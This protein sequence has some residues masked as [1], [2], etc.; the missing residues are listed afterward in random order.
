ML[1]WILMAGS[2]CFA[3]T[4][5]QEKPNTENIRKLLVLTGSGEIGAQ[6]MER[7]IDNFKVTIPDVPASFWDEFKTEVNPNTLIDLIVP[8]Y[9]NHLSNEE[10]DALI[11]FYETPAGKKFTAAL[12]E[13]SQESMLA[14]EAWGRQI[15]EKVIK[16]LK[17]SGKFSQKDFE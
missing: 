2:F 3:N 13:I 11:A 10:I 12:P 6:V 5:N 8:I 15:A 4:Q 16:K 14:G 7:M 1:I 17:K 9:A